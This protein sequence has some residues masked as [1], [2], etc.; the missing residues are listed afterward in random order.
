[1]FMQK[2]ELY[3]LMG[4]T[5]DRAAFKTN[6]KVL[7]QKHTSSLSQSPLS[8]KLRVHA[9]VLM[10]NH[11]HLL[12]EC[13]EDTLGSSHTLDLSQERIAN[14]RA[15]RETY[16]YIFMNP[17]R[18][19]LCRLPQH[20]PYSTFHYQFHQKFLPFSLYSRLSLGLGGTEGE[21][22]WILRETKLRETKLNEAKLYESSRFRYSFTS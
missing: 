3:H 6:L 13:S 5:K 21:L 17:V 15:Y 19:H 2:Y 20:Y 16:C 12:A 4:R 1:M 22:R 10:P 11:F 9:F 8:S 14:A 18:A 7:W